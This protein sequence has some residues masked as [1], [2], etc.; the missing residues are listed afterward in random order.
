VTGLRNFLL[1]RAVGFVPT[2]FISLA[3]DS[4][5]CIHK[6]V[7][8]LPRCDAQKLLGLFDASHR[9]LGWIKQSHLHK[10]RALVPPD[11]LVCDFRVLEFHHDD[12]WDFHIFAGGRHPRQQIIHCVSCVKLR[13]N[14]STTWSLPT[15]REIGVT[16]ASLGSWFMKCSL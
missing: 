11:V 15:V 9:Q 12:V 6:S 13:T 7:P 8:F 2:V 10:Q 3:R 4:G 1:V 5:K 16:F 14:S